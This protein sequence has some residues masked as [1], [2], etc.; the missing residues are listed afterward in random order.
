MHLVE[1]R[2]L[3]TKMNKIEKLNV[4]ERT[5]DGDIAYKTD[6]MY[7]LYLKINEL[8]EVVNKLQEGEK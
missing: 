7:L 2:R 1:R 5:D 6:F 3:A 8:I 4:P